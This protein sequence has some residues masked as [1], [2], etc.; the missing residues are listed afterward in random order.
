M[1]TSTPPEIPAQLLSRAR[2]C[3]SAPGPAPPPLATRIPPGSSRGRPW[4]A[5]VSCL[6]RVLLTQSRSA[7]ASGRTMPLS[8]LPCVTVIR[9]LLLCSNNV[10]IERVRLRSVFFFRPR[11]PKI[12][13]V[14]VCDAT[15]ACAHDG[16]GGRTVQ[17]V[18]CRPAFAAHGWEVSGSGVG[19]GD[20]AYDPRRQR[21]ED[22]RRRK[23]RPSPCR[24][25]RRTYRPCR[26]RL[27]SLGTDPLI[28]PF[29]SS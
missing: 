25:V 6:R 29:R 15:I 9:R 11:A 5:T 12:K 24:M 7:V 19:R 21:R 16:G 26:R 14:L 18:R 20:R 23:H 27:S 22:E 8:S 4:R 10:P 17:R 3:Q 13:E 2:V 1:Q 28:A